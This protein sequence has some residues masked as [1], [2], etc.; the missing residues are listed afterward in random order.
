MAWVSCTLSAQRFQDVNV[1]PKS[2][3][4][5]K[6]KTVTL[7]LYAPEA[8]S[9]YLVAGGL[10]NALGG[11]K[12]MAK[13][14]SGVF[15]IN[16]GPLEPDIY[17]YGFSIDGSHR[18]ID[19]ANPNVEEL[20][21]GSLSYFEVPAETQQ[22]YNS[23][24]VAHGCVVNDWYHSEKIGSIRPLQIYLP[25]GYL[26][27]DDR[28]PVLYLLHGAGQTERSWVDVGKV[29]FILDNLLAEG[30]I[31]PMIVVMPYGHLKREFVLRDPD[32]RKLESDLIHKT[33]VEEIIPFVQS[34]YRTASERENRAIAGLSMGSGQSKNITLNNPGMFACCGIFS[35]S[36]NESDLTVLIEDP[37]GQ[38]LKLL[39]LGASYSEPAF[40]SQKQ[41]QG[42]AAQNPAFVLHSGKGGH[43]F[44]YW[45]LCMVDFLPRL[46]QS[47]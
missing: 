18:T 26:Q 30:K 47:K 34:K 23:Q 4:I 41:Y 44:V 39:W 25:P 43:T 40:E 7:R 31:K 27:S 17:D 35:G 16:I 15:E 2:P 21:W 28:Y 20:K 19:P 14:A 36:I 3:E 45:R 24:P 13:S 29:N 8:D 1:L 12:K 32:F 42:K 46:F 22:Y 33:M 37:A 5:H 38:K 9:V 10:E 11:P 6:D